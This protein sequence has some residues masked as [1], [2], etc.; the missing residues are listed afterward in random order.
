MNT[1]TTRFAGFPHEAGELSAYLFSVDT[2][3]ISL[4]NEK[5]IRYTATEPEL[6]RSWLEHH[7]IRN[8]RDEVG[9]M[10][11]H[12]YFPNAEHSTR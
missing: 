9:N 3:I 6:F 10:I 4:K 8:V 1:F 2:F 12:F 5:I 11:Y 7:C